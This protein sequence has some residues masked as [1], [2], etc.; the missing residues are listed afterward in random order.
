MRISVIGVGS[1]QGDDAL[2]LLV[3]ERLRAAALPP[4]VSVFACEHPEIDLLPRLAEADAVVLVDATRS[5]R[6]PGALHRPV[7]ASLSAGPAL[8]S[9]GMGVA[10]LLALARSLDRAPGQLELIGVEAGDVV[11]GPP[12]APVLEAVPAACA[13]V[14]EQVSR[15]CAGREG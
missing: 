15:W 4:G 1:H 9:H 10:G 5:G 8:S 7:E 6:A 3:A 2:G 12:S 13:L 14:Q 11:D